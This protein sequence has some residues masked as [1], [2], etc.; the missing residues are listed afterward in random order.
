MELQLHVKQTQTLSPQMVQAMEVLQMGTQEL[1]EYIQET[2]QENP[3]LESE[4]PREQPRPVE[5][6]EPQE[7]GED[8]SQLRRKLEWLEDT[9]RQNSWYH[10]QE[11]QDEEQ[12]AAYETAAPMEES[13]FDHLRGQ[14]RFRELDRRLA[15]AV[16][17]VLE[18]LNRCGWL[19]ED[20]GEL[21]ERLGLPSA[22]VAEAVA[23]VQG[24]EPAGVGARSL[25]E[26]LVLQ[27]RRQGETGLAVTIAQRYL[28][29][30]GRDHY[31]RI[32]KE[33]RSSREA[34]QDACRQIR[35]LSPRPGSA[36]GCQDT[37]RYI[38]PDLLVTRE[39]GRFEVAAND[40]Y[41]PAL[42]LSGYYRQLSQD[43]EDK[44]VQEYLSG[45][46]RQAKWV[47]R[48]VEQRRSTLLSCAICLVAR[49]E[50]FFLHGPGHLQPLSLRDVAEAVAVHES[51]VSRAVKDKYLQCAFGVF[52]LSY[53]FS[54]SVG[55]EEGTSPSRAKAALTALIRDE[56]KKKPLS[57]Q[58]L[59]E[60]LGAQGVELSR[61]T[62]AK[63]RD[64]LGIPST[65][66]RK[67]F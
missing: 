64:E 2:L 32:A 25:S 20:D 7:G 55:G 31:N 58:K 63:Y 61:R 28:E 65:T 53:F 48:S 14:V 36:F 46:L 50:A 30:M 57:D 40:R 42:R 22:L 17:G 45:K 41:F 44:Q 37:A 38:V 52:P 33:T 6:Q 23:L 4:D 29:D 9:D 66:G 59:V 43:T 21:A 5:L 16:L 3:T 47:M 24:L 15:T 10:R 39:E 18:S 54:R 19:D 8:W 56:D 1:L 51:T 13:L 49:Q 11:V 35:A 67:E 27:L 62:V 34:V 60:L 12:T 26:C